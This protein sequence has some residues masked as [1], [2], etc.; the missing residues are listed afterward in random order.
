MDT[1]F[2]RYDRNLMPIRRPNRTAH[3]SSK[4]FQRGEAATKMSTKNTFTAKD[5][6]STKFLYK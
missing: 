3:V 5:I 1:G 6:K 4:E 2:R